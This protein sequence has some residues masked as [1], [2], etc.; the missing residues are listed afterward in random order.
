VIK[1][2]K[3]NEN[4]AADALSR[5]EHEAKEGEVMT[6]TEITLK[7]MEDLKDIYQNDN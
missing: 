3:G 1:Y 6:V 7:W 5:R 2:K 4:K